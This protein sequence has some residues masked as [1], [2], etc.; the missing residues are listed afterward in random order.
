MTS[1]LPIDLEEQFILVLTVYIL[2]LLGNRKP[3]KV[4]VLRFIKA[5]GLITFYE[6][7]SARRST[8]EE[9]WMNDFAWAR[10]DA[11]RRGLLKMPEIGIWQLSDAG[12][13]WLIERAKRW[14]EIYEKD[15]SSKSV[16]LSR[17]RR[18][19]DIAFTHVILIGRGDDVTKKPATLL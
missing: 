17:C 8:G 18:V 10:E 7:D 3:E 15:P 16:F 6:D 2:E 11:K 13:T 4:Q 14:V 12:R 1:F 5:R 9:K 19:N